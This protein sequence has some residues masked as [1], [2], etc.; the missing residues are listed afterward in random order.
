MTGRDSRRDTWWKE[1][2]TKA[3]ARVREGLKEDPV[4]GPDA[5]VAAVTAS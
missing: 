1:L 3:A 2:K 4:K 5:N